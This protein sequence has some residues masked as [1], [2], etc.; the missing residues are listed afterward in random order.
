VRSGQQCVHDISDLR[1]AG[2]IFTVSM[3]YLTV[4]AYR[5]ERICTEWKVEGRTGRGCLDELL[6]R[7][8]E[9]KEL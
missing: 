8:F 2:T 6:W 7:V 1:G 5:I 4:Y 9:P 3:L